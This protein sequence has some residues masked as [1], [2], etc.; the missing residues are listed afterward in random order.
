MGGTNFTNF[1]LYGIHMVVVVVDVCSS[2]LSISIVQW[3]AAHCKNICG[4]E[5]VCV[6]SASTT[7]T[8]PFTESAA[9]WLFSAALC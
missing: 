6:T 1:W 7:C 9:K 4:I 8:E 2:D 3:M 5:H